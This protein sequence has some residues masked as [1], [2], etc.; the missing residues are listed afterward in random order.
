M[1]SNANSQNSHFTDPP[2]PPLSK[3]NRKSKAR[4][5]ARKPPVRAWRSLCLIVDSAL[6]LVLDRADDRG[7]DRAARATRNYLRDYATDTEVA[8]LCRRNKRW[9][10]QR[11]DLTKYAAADDA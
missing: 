5:N 3:R 9:Q 7:E 8:A 6:S 11:H 4:E 10:N 1:L 2:D